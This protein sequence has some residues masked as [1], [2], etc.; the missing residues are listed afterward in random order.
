[1]DVE[2]FLDWEI[3][4]DRF[5]DVIDVP[6]SKQVKMVANRLKSIAAVWW[7][8]LIVHRQ[9]QRKNPISTWRRIKQLMLKRFNSRDRFSLSPL[10]S[11]K[12]LERKQLPSP[13]MYQTSVK[14]GYDE[15]MKEKLSK[16]L[17]Y[18]GKLS[19]D[20]DMENKKALTIKRS[21]FL[22]WK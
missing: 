12:N 4:V 17:G 1:M 7:D 3:D 6:E 8:R 9:R 18:G 22:S 15:N 2:K 13:R 14:G 19:H 10:V 11:I 16:D 21:N 5:F 20:A